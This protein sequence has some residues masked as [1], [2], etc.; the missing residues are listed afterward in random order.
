MDNII[1]SA[2][3]V[4]M[5]M[6]SACLILWAVMPEWKSIMLGLLAGLAASAMNA[7]LLKRRVGMISDAALEEGSRRKGL[8]FGNRIATVLLVAMLAYRYPEILNMPAALLGSM[9]MPFI[10]LTVAIIHT[11]KENN[12]GKG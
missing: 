4:L 1:K 2:T 3:R 10:I 7:F 11:I 5:F 12:S 6:M 8:G 9:V